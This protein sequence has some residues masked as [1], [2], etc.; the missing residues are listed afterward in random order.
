[1]PKRCK[2]GG[3]YYHVWETPRAFAVRCNKCN[4]KHVQHKRK[5]VKIWK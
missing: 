5:A 2:C 4:T 3:T 1:M